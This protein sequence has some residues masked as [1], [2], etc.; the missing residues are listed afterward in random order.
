MPNK[1]ELRHCWFFAQDTDVLILALTCFERL[2][3]QYFFVPRVGE[4]ISLRNICMLQGANRIEALPWFLDVT[5]QEVYFIKE[6]SK[7][8]Y[9]KAFITVTEGELSAMRSLGSSE[10]VTNEVTLEL[11]AFICR[12][13]QP[14]AN[15]KIL[16][17]LRWLMFTKNETLTDSLPPTRSSLMPAIQ[18]ANFQSFIWRQADLSKPTVLSPIGHGWFLECE[19]LTSLIRDKACAPDAVLKLIKCAC[20]KSR[21]LSHC[22]CTGNGLPCTE[23]CN[24]S[25][26]TTLCDNADKTD[27]VVAHISDEDSSKA[28]DISD[29]D[30]D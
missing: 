12:V 29:S 8:S 19:Q 5:Q 14:N 11:E 28:S 24:C 2:P 3:E 26:D 23:M 15:I 22:K 7:L 20:E 18:R 27:G 21:C 9:W 4:Y 1:E 6:N 25:G 17:N 13:Y 30:D 16:A 10:T